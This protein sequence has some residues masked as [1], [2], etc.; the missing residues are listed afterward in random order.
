MSITK[1]NTQ[2]GGRGLQKQL[3]GAFGLVVLFFV[4]LST[5]M[6]WEMGGINQHLVDL[7]DNDLNPLIDA[8]E[9]NLALLE[10]DKDLLEIIIENDPAKRAILEADL[11]VNE[12]EMLSRLKLLEAEVD[13]TEL[14]ALKG[15]ARAFRTWV[16][17]RQ[18]GGLL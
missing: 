12:E 6:V 11:V 7:H 16:G 2:V 10:Q 15:F 9:A 17:V 13:E 4:A 8:A 5:F 3:L 1:I 14:E 18:R